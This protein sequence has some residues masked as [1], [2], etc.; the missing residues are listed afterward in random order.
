MLFFLSQTMDIKFM[1]EG[2]ESY[3]FFQAI[4]LLIGIAI[5]KIVIDGIIFL[6]L[7]FIYPQIFV[8]KV[9]WA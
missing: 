9:F 8:S 3:H 1:G 6:S 2:K 5:M 4:K 7:N